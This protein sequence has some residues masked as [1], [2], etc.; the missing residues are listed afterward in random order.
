MGPKKRCEACKKDR[1]TCDGAIPCFR[2]KDKA[3]K[4]TE[5]EI[6]Q[7]KD[8][9]H[10]PECFYSHLAEQ[11]R[12]TGLLSHVVRQ[13]V[14]ALGSAEV[15]E[16]EAAQ[17]R[18]AMAEAQNAAAFRQSKRGKAMVSKTAAAVEGSHDGS[19]EQRNAEE[20]AVRVSKEDVERN[21]TKILAL[22]SVRKTLRVT[23]G[24]GNGFVV[25]VEHRAFPGKIY[26]LKISQKRAQGDQELHCDVSSLRKEYRNITMCASIPQCI[27]MAQVPGFDLGLASHNNNNVVEYLGLFMDW[28]DAVDVRSAGG[29]A[30][31]W[32]GA[33]LECMK[34]LV[35]GVDAMHKLGL[36]HADIKPGNVLIHR[37][38]QRITICDMGMT[39][40]A[41]V[42]LS[43]YGTPGYRAPE[44][45]YDSLSQ[46]ANGAAKDAD[47]WA[48]GVTLIIFAIAHHSLV[49]K[50][51]D[52]KDRDRSHRQ[53]RVLATKSREG[54]GWAQK[55]ASRDSTI[56]V[57]RNVNWTFIEKLLTYEAT[58]RAKALR[59]FSQ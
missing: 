3:R 34:Q 4:R 38:L 28:I 23:P 10:T 25:P 16:A 29:E 11:T 48:V 17:K 7:G 57:I 45:V 21:I 56:K 18:K 54:A 44:F 47:R 1:Q 33:G 36:V 50:E 6:T 42:G 8:K 27:D 58:G 35:Q 49:K 15:A 9:V 55:F 32:N 19:G 39:T 14:K 41:S 43:R 13:T 26:A 51:A 24:G 22:L 30:A 59:E 40:Y 31:W 12:L 5:W 53:D 46:K 2:C 37:G 20:T 52:D